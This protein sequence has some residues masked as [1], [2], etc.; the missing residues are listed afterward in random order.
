MTVNVDLVLPAQPVSGSTIYIPLAGNGYTSPHSAFAVSA[1]VTMDASG[2]V[3]ALRLARDER[4]EHLVVLM[5]ALVSNTTVAPI[6]FD[7]TS[8]S[9]AVSFVTSKIPTL[10]PGG[11][12]AAIFTPPPI[13]N[14]I[15]MNIRAANVDSFTLTASFMVYNFKIDASKQIPLDVL[16][17]SVPTGGSLT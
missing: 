15:T 10:L 14:P 16:L 3:A 9:T 1:V 5:A 4:W 11:T 2:G 8:T 7:I 13:I 6:Q 17:A 12:Q